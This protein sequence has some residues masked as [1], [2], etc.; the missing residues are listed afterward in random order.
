M[1]CSLGWRSNKNTRVSGKASIVCNWDHFLMDYG[2]EHLIEGHE[3]HRWDWLAVANPLCA[4]WPSAAQPEEVQ[5]LPRYLS[6]WH[7]KHL[8]ILPYVGSKKFFSD[9]NI[10]TGETSPAITPYH[11]YHFSISTSL[12]FITSK[13]PSLNNIQHLITFTTR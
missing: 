10:A 4:L 2:E 3:T 7:W 9:L 12:T 6:P 11:T 5:L 1:G 13:L 8:H